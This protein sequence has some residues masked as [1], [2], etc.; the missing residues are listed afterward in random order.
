MVRPKSD[1]SEPKDS[2]KSITRA[3]AVKIDAAVKKT[4]LRISKNLV[5]L[6]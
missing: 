3:S 4:S 6:M 1:I 2:R 5:P